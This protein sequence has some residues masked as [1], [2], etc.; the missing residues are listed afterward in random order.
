MLKFNELFSAR[1]REGPILLHCS[2]STDSVSGYHIDTGRNVQTIKPLPPIRKQNKI[3]RD[4]EVGSHS[5]H[6]KHQAAEERK[7]V[8]PSL[9][10]DFKLGAQNILKMEQF[11]MLLTRMAN[12]AENIQVKA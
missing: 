3:H 9:T 7:M 12:M 4:D 8:Y 11:G 2:V 6:H 10:S 5:K 1:S